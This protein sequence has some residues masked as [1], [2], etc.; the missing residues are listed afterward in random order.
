MRRV[1]IALAIAA[2]GGKAVIDPVGTGGGGGTAPDDDDGSPICFTPDPVGEAFVCD[3][4]SGA[5]AGA[6]LE[7]FTTL[8]DSDA[9]LWTSRCKGDSCECIFNGEQRCI[10]SINEPGNTFC[11]GLPS[12]CPEPFPP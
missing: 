1:L 7:C 11:A 5:G 12:C 10:C 3:G 2:C 8:C 9:N 6:P 4:T